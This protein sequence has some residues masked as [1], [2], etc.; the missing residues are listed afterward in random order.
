MRGDDID[1]IWGKRAGEN[2]QDLASGIITK[3]GLQKRD[4]VTERPDELVIGRGDAPDTDRPL[5]TGRDG[6]TA[7]PG[8]HLSDQNDSSSSW[9]N[10][11]SVQ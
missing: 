10:S 11:A 3:L 7:Q 5:I 8:R 4:K 9:Q 6:V 1:C 2:L